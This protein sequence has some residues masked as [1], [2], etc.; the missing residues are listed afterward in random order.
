[1]KGKHLENPQLR[2]HIRL[3]PNKFGI[4]LAIH[5]LISTILGVKLIRDGKDS[6]EGMTSGIGSVFLVGSA[7][8][9]G[10]SIPL[11]ISSSKR[12]KERDELLKLF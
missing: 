11:F 7:I 4:T 5:S 2:L 9:G 1:M 8:S 3:A 12:K 6:E 10:F